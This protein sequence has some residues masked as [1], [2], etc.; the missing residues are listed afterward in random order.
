ML[1]MPYCV[2]TF[3]FLIILLDLEF[4]IVFVCFVYLDSI[5]KL[6]YTWIFCLLLSLVCYTEIYVRV[7]IKLYIK[8]I[9]SISNYEALHAFIQYI[10]S[11]IHF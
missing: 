1:L 10:H 5:I 9:G 4:W 6:L 11:L 2:L 7:K 3:A 8:L